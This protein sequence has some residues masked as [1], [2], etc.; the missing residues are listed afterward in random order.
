VAAGHGSLIWAASAAV[1]EELVAAIGAALADEQPTP[2]IGWQPTAAGRLR[3][4]LAPHGAVEAGP[5]YV[6]ADP[7]TST[8]L[9]ASADVRTSADPDAEAVRALLPTGDRHLIPPWAIGVVGGVAA[10]VCETARD[11]PHAVEAGVWTYEPHR[12]QGLATAVVARWAGLVGRRTAF[13][14]TDASNLASQAVARRLG[15]TPV[16]QWWRVRPEGAQA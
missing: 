14:S 15:A 1:P 3:E 10:A 12:R 5:S 16:G 2:A 13:Y 11:A 4:L 6:L 7:P 8:T 9:P